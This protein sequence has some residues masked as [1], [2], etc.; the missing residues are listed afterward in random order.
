MNSRADVDA[1]LSQLG[2]RTVEKSE[3]GEVFTPVTVI[4][5]MLAALPRRVWSDPDLKWC[6]PACGVGNYPLKIMFGG[7]GYTG[8]LDGLAAAMP[9]PAHRLRHILEHMLYCAD[10]NATSIRTLRHTLGELAPGVIPNV[11]TRDFLA[12]G[13]AADDDVYDIIVGNPPYN[14]GGTKRVGE[15]RMHVR[16]TTRALARL[17]PGGGYLAFVC[18]PNYREAGST[19]NAAFRD[20]AGGHFEYIRI[21]GPNETHKLFKVQARVDSFIWHSGGGADRGTTIVD[22][23]GTR[24]TNVA[25]DLTRHVPN[26]GFSVFEKLRSV[27]PLRPKAYRTTEATTITCEKS[28]FV[29]TGAHKVVHL[30]VEGGM[31]ILRRNKPHALQHTPKIIMNGLGVPY[32]MYDREGKYGVTQTPVVIE[33]PPAGLYTFMRSPLFYCMLWGLRITGNNNLPYMLEDIPADYGK[34]LTFSAD[35]QALIASFRVPEFENVELDAGGG[36]CSGGRRR[37]RKRTTPRS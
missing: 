6:D 20:A 23:R 22:E 2:R 9:N 31:K 29:A 25:L 36:T 14:A 21:Y 33:R 34:S 30:I 4:D 26:F 7:T 28:G 32:V 35:E 24:H 12:T 15:K 11:E 17:R 8:L 16:F 27:A 10:I 13:G 18:P 19:M 3:Y 5:D 37:T 1:Y